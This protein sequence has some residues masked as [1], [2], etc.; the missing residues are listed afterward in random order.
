[1]ISSSMLKKE[2]SAVQKM[3]NLA[4]VTF[5]GYENEL[6]GILTSFILRLSNCV[7]PM[8]IER[9]NNLRR[10]IDRLASLAAGAL[11][12]IAVAPFTQSRL[13]PIYEEPYGKPD[14]PKESGLHFSLSHTRAYAC[15]A[16]SLRPVGVDVEEHIDPYE[17]LCAMC[18][19]NAED[20]YL[21]SYPDRAGRIRA[22]T[23]LWTRKEALGKYLGCGMDDSVLCTDMLHWPGSAVKLLAFWQTDDMCRSTPSLKTFD[24][25]EG[26]IS[27]CGHGDVCLSN[28]TLDGLLAAHSLLP[29]TTYENASDN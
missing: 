9:A 19:T 10:P 8:R 15:C 26:C 23:Q 4:Y 17:D 25:C 7:L 18:L 21:K 6:D 16:V 24:L 29:T 2:A 13:I 1:M 20:T 28:Y 12:D 3:I 11:L 27:V 5:D 14:F 22:F